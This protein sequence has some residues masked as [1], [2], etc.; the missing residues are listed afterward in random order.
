MY[1]WRAQLGIVVPATNTTVE[2]E[3]H[4]ALPDGVAMFASRVPVA[5]VARRE[6]KVASLLAMHEGLAEAAAQVGA[7]RP[8]AVAYACTSGSFL[9]GAGSD[10]DLCRRMHEA[11]G[12]PALTTSTA[13]AAALKAVGASRI[14]LVTPYVTEVAA[15]AEAYLA[16]LGVEVVARADLN[17]LSN[18]E[19]GML[20][21]TASY[22]LARTV[23]VAGADAVLISCTNWRTLDIIGRLEADLGRPVVSSNSATLWALLRLAGI[24]DTGSVDGALLRSGLDWLPEHVTRAGAR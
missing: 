17:L 5:E 13:V 2:P 14:A 1:G 10:R 18:L 23:D 8:D 24:P 22:R 16:E 7:A 6:D 19:K 3:L 20:P 4:R 21:A 9:G 15:G 12:V 11:T